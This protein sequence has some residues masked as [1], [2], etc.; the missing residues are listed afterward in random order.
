MSRPTDMRSE[1]SSC[2]KRIFPNK[3]NERAPKI[4]IQIAINTSRSIQWYCTTKS[5]FDKNLN[6]NANSKKPN[7]TFTVFI[8]PPDLGS[9]CNHPG[10]AANSAKGKAMANEN[11]NIPIIG[12]IPP[13][14]AA[15]TNKE[16]T[17][18]PV[19]EKDTMAKANAIKKIP[20]KPLRSAWASILVLHELGRVISKAPKNEIE[21]TTKIKKNIMLNKKLLENAFSTSAPKI[22]VTT[23]PNNT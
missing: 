16:P 12:A 21:K 18:G 14:E 10:K 11:P 20:T 9:D 19:H 22:A 4:A 23:V 13:C 8:Q 3:Y 17:I 7:T 6:A 5:A 2:G 1:A 15:C